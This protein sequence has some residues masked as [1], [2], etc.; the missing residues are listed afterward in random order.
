MFELKKILK[1]IKF[2]L[3]YKG[4]CVGL[5]RKVNG[6]YETLLGLRKHSPKGWSFPGG[7]YEKKDEKS[8]FKTALRE[9][10]EETDLNLKNSAKEET[11]I[12]F[13][14]GIPFFSKV[15]TYMYEVPSDFP[16]P[17]WWDPNEFLDMKFVPL[18]KVKELSKNNKNRFLYFLVELEIIK[19]LLIKFLWKFSK[20]AYR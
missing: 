2:F 20:K 10:S 8:L 4:A 5:F 18:R 19:F 12:I 11:A 15:R 7:G 17:T 1:N 3:F 13:S 16:A 6:T 14:I 9:L